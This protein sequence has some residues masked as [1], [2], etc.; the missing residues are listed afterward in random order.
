MTATLTLELIA[1]I[2]ALWLDNFDTAE[3]AAAMLLPEYVIWN[4]RCY[5]PEPAKVIPIKER[6]PT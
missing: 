4:S 5:M 2:R 1:E 3:I 6:K